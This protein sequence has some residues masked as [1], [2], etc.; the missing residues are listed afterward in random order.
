MGMIP[1]VYSCSGGSHEEC[2]LHHHLAACCV[3]AAVCTAGPPSH[4]AWAQVSKGEFIL[5]GAG[6]F[7]PPLSPG[8]GLKG[9]CWA[10]PLCQLTGSWPACHIWV[11]HG[12]SVLCGTEGDLVSDQCT[13]LPLVCSQ[14]QR[15]SAST[16]SCTVRLGG[17][18]RPH[19]PA[20]AAG[21]QRL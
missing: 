10:W 17:V 12:W 8:E 2:G 3:P 14:E 19:Q 6:C 20:S 1:A 4:E 18:C 15:V 13:F 5:R 9:A 7:P 16:L 11:C 21:G